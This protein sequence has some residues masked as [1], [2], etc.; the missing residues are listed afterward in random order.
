VYI[1]PKTPGNHLF[2]TRSKKTLTK[3]PKATFKV[4]Q[5]NQVTCPD[6]IVWTEEFK[7]GLGF[8]IGPPQ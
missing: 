3:M 8:E 4:L 7:S 1:V 6:Y 2:D 5:K